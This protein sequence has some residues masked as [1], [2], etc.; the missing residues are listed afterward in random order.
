MTQRH[1]GQTKLEF[2]M[3]TKL[4]KMHVTGLFFIGVTV[5]LVTV[6]VI[7]ENMEEEELIYLHY[8]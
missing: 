8:L 5:A 1:S 4:M 2:I 7:W 6:F 3:N